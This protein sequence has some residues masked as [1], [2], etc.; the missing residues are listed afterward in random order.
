M[1]C[2]EPGAAAA[3]T[4]DLTVIGGGVYGIALCLEASRQGLK[5]LLVERG[6]FGGETSWNSLRILHGGL[7]YLQTLDL[8]RFRESVAAR[9]WWMR[10]YPELVQPLACVMPLYGQGLKRP[11]VLRLALAANHLLSVTRNRGVRADRHLEPGRVVSTSELEQM[12]PSLDFTAAEAGALWYDAVMPSSERILIEMLHWAAAYGSNCL[13]YMEAKRLLN[14]GSRVSGL[15]CRDLI[16]D[17]EI[18]FTT[19]SVV[20]C[21]GPWSRQLMTGFHRDLPELFRPSL[22][23]N[24]LLDRD[25]LGEAALAV[26]PRGEGSKAFFL[27]PWQGRVLAGTFHATLPDDPQ[28]DLAEIRDHSVQQFL[29]QLNAA[30]PDLQLTS[31]DVLLVQA[32]QLPARSPGSTAL[33][34]RPIVLHLGDCGAP[35][36]LFAVSGVKFTTARQV[37]LET[38]TTLQRFFGSI[39]RP[40]AIIDRPEIR[41]VPDWDQFE[42]LSR[43][44]PEKARQLLTE[45]AQQESA[46]GAGDLLFRRTTWWA[47]GAAERSARAETIAHHLDWETTH[48]PDDLSTTPRP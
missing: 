15:I 47:T 1:I 20:S 39:P 40:R 43:S 30:S 36:G 14:H 9:H 11:A 41:T 31:S 34:T 21:A 16:S 23:L 44:N 45:I 22:A 46:H 37:A 38:V 32:G 3:T 13:N 26:S 7:R 2:R 18:R 33:A 8:K 48:L 27:C 10:T 17:Q 4:Y 42:I 19:R 24:L 12:F 35:T 6:D 5:T 29:D 25:S 28:R